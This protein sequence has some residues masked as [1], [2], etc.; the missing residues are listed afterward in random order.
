MTGDTRQA[1]YLGL[2]NSQRLLHAAHASCRLIEMWKTGEWAIAVV[3]GADAEIR[4]IMYRNV[5][6]SL[7]EER[8][9][10]FPVRNMILEALFHHAVNRWFS[11]HNASG[12]RGFHLEKRLYPKEYHDVFRDL[13]K[14]RHKVTAHW[15]LRRGNFHDGTDRE[16]IGTADDGLLPSFPAPGLTG[17]L[18]KRFRDILLWGLT[19]C[20]I[21]IWGAHWSSS[22]PEKRRV[23]MDGFQY[24]EGMATE[25]EAVLG[26]DGLRSKLDALREIYECA[27]EC[28]DDDMR[29]LVERGLKEGLVMWSL[30]SAGGIVGRESDDGGR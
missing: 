5:L 30:G 28:S 25:H 23:T 21:K 8:Q 18:Y 14:Y 27:G 3:K 9:H 10:P 22:S 20:T 2:V 16:M 1:E 24:L 12:Q 7:S 29:A 15:E 13:T 6:T 17:A 11:A 19:Y 26:S 4:N